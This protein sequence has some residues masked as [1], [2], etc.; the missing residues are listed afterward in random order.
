LRR[1]VHVVDLENGFFEAIDRECRVAVVGKWP[2]PG[3]EGG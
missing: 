3:S 1:N 2:S